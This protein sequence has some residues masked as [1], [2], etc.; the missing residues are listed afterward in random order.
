MPPKTS[1][2]L[3]QRRAAALRKLDELASYLYSLAERFFPRDARRLREYIARR[4]EGAREILLH[5][6]ERIAGV[7]RLA[8]NAYMLTIVSSRYAGR[9][10]R[11]E[12][13]AQKTLE[14]RVKLLPPRLEEAVYYVEIG[15]YALKCTC[16]DAVYAS[17][18]AD[19][20]LAS[21]GFPPQAYK[22]SLCKH[23]LAGLALLWAE[24]LIDP[25]RPPF[26]EALLRALVTVYLATLPPGKKP[27]VSRIALVYT[28][29]ETSTP[30]TQ[31]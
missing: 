23:I 2:T 14:G 30:V 1:L 11:L 6:E 25:T 3:Q 9:G 15:P 27:K 19:Q 31:N 18:R 21:L 28:R 24:N 4:V 17:A 10:V 13:V 26:D 5:P 16:P 29:G 7:R 8:E 22:Y 12:P 20:R